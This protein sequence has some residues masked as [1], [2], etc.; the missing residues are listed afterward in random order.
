MGP[1]HNAAATA[2]PAP[3]P[4]LLF[5]CLLPLLSGGANPP[6]SD[7]P[8]SVGA[9][10]AMCDALCVAVARL[11]LEQPAEQQRPANMPRDR[12]AKAAAAAAAACAPATLAAVHALLESEATPPALLPP[13]LRLL[14][15][16]AA[17]APGALRALGGD[18]A[19]LLL[20]WALDAGVCAAGRALIPEALRALAPCWEAP[21]A[22]AAAAGVARSVLADLERLAPAAA[23]GTAAGPAGL[24]PPQFCGLAAC[25]VALARGFPR[26]RQS[27]GG[28]GADGG[29]D[30]A[31]G[32]DLGDVPGRLLWL[33]LAVQ[34]R[35]AAAAAEAVEASGGCGGAAAKEA[36]RELARLAL[37]AASVA[38]DGDEGW[39]GAA[40]GALQAALACLEA[41]A[42]MPRAAAAQ[43]L[44]A[45]ALLLC[46]SAESGREGA[47]ALRAALAAA[48]PRL[49]AATAPLRAS[50]HGDVAAA[51]A[52]L[53]LAALRQCGDT[54]AAALGAVALAALVE[55]V[56]ALSEREIGSS[57]GEGEALRLLAFDLA[58]LEAWA[59][60][61]GG[62]AMPLTQALAAARVAAA[63]L[64]RTALSPDGGGAAGEEAAAELSTLCVRL[65]AALPRGA[66]KA[67]APDAGAA[68][69]QAQL[70]EAAGEGLLLAVEAGARV[71]PADQELALRAA[72]EAA[73]RGAAAL[74]DEG[75][76]I[77]AADRA[78]SM[79]ARAADS[80]EAR[81][82][83]AAVAAAAAAAHSALL[84][85]GPPDGRGG[86]DAAARAL[87]VV[88]ALASD[89][90]GATAA[91]AQAALCDLAL[92]AYLL[93]AARSGRDS[94]G[95]SDGSVGSGCDPWAPSRRER[96]ALQRPVRAFRS[97]QLAALF[98]GLMRAP[99]GL[100]LLTR[101]AA[102]AAAAA[103]PGAGDADGG[104]LAGPA[105]LALARELPPL[106]PSAAGGEAPAATA[107]AKKQGRRQQQEQQPQ[108]PQQPPPQQQQ[109]QSQQPP[110][111]EPIDPSQL[112]AASEAAWFL[113][114]EAARHCAAARMRTH[115]GGPTESFAGLERLLQGALARL[116][117]AAAA[118]AAAAAGAAA[119]AGKPKDEAASAAA[120]AAA[121]AELALLRQRHGAA[122]LLEFAF[123]LEAGVLA[124]AEGCAGRAAP[125]QAALAFFAANKRVRCRTR[126]SH[127]HAWQQPSCTTLAPCWLAAPIDTFL[128]HL[129]IQNTH[130]HTQP[131]VC[132]EWFARQRGTLARLAAA[133]GLPH[134][135]LHH[136]GARLLDVK[137]QLGSLAAADS[138]FKRRLQQ[139]KRNEEEQGAAGAVVA[140]EPASPAPA[141]HGGRSGGRGRGGRGGRGKGRGREPAAPG[142][143]KPAAAPAL[144][145]EEHAA[146]RDAALR[147]LAPTAAEALAACAAALVALRDADGVRGLRDWAADAFAPLWKLEAQRFEFLSGGGGGS[148]ISS[149]SAE[150]GASSPAGGGG[151]SAAGAAF[152]LSWLDG[153]E[154]AAAGRP[155]DAARLLARFLSRLPQGG[156]SGGESGAGGDGIGGPALGAAVQGLLAEQLG[157]AYAALADWRAL[158]ALQA[159]VR[160]EAG[161]LRAAA[162]AAASA[163]AAAAEEAQQSG[164]GGG[165]GG[166]DAAGAAAAAAAAQAR[167]MAARAAAA[168]A[169]AQGADTALL[170]CWAFAGADAEALR[171]ATPSSTSGLIAVCLAT[172]DAKAVGGAVARQLPAAA[173]ALADD[174]RRRAALLGEWAGAAAFLGA[175]AAAPNLQHLAALRLL[176][177]LMATAPAAKTGAA[178]ASPLAAAAGAIDQ[179]LAVGD[180]QGSGGGGGGGW[181]A[182]LSDDGSVA[183][184]RL[185]LS[186][187]QLSP[188]L[189]LLE[190]GRK[191]PAAAGGEECA[192]L[193]GVVQRRAA[194]AAWEAG[195]AASL[196]R[197]IA[198]AAADADAG[199]SGGEAGGQQRQ[200]L[201]IVGSR[202]LLDCVPRADAE[203][204]QAAMA[205]A[206]KEHTSAL[207]RLAGGAAPE[208]SDAVAAMSLFTILQ[209]RRQQQLGAEEA[210]W[211]GLYAS[212]A[213]RL[214]LSMPS[215]D[216]IASAG[217]LL[218]AAACC[219]VAVAAAPARPGAWRAL[220]DFAY[221]LA[222][223]QLEQQQ[224]GDDQEQ[225]DAPA[226]APVTLPPD[227]AAAY[228][229]AADAYS[230]HLATAAASRRLSAAEDGLPAL[231]RLLRLVLRRAAPLE[232]PL[233]AA[234]LRTPAAAWQALA[235]QLLSALGHAD[236]AARRLAALLLRGVAAAAP[237]AV[238]Y[239]SIA[240]L[241][242]A[243][244]RGSGG[245]AA[246]A[247]APSAP[248]PAASPE[249]ESVLRVLRR[250]D[251][252]LVADAAAL[253]DG[254]EALTV[255]P[256]E[257][258]AALLAELE[259]GVARK[260]LALRADAARIEAS[261]RVPRARRAELLAARYS[262]LVA[263]A[264]AAL[265]RQLAASTAGAPASR[266]DAEFRAT[267]LPA[268]ARAI[269]AFRS[270]ARVAAALTAEPGDGSSAGAGPGAAAE[271]PAVAWAPLKALQQALAAR[272][273]R[274]GA[275]DLPA[276]APA[277]AALRAGAIPM[278]AD[279]LTRGALPPL[280]L[281]DAAGGDDAASASSGALPPPPPLV[282]EY[283][284]ITAI[285]P[286]ALV[287]PTKTRPKRLRLLASDGAAHAFLLKG[288]D[289]LRVDE[290]LMQFVRAA[291]AAARD[292]AAL[293][294]AG[295]AGG[296]GGCGGAA[297]P[298]IELRQYS[299]TPL[300]PRAGLVQWVRGTASVFALFR[301][302]QAAAAARLEAV[303]AARRAA[304]AAAAAAPAAATS[305]AAAAGGGRGGR[306][307][308]GKRKAKMQA[309]AAVGKD[310]AQSEAPPQPPLQLPL[311]VAAARPADAYYA[312]L[313]PALRAAGA[314]PDAPREAWPRAALRATFASLARDAPRRLLAD[315][316][317]AGAGSAPAWWAR[318]RRY[319][320]SAAA[321]AIVGWLLGVG[322][323]HPDNILLDR[324]T[325]EVV[326]VD[327]SVCLDKG[328][329][330]RV[331]EVVPFRLTPALQAALGP[332]GKEGAFRA[333]CERA[334]RS[335]RASRAPLA[336]LLALLLEDPGVDW[337]AEREAQAARRAADAA[338]ALEL[339]ASRMDEVRRPLLAALRGALPLAGDALAA[340]CAYGAAHAFMRGA[341]ERAA[342]ARAE[343]A[344]A[345]DSAARA[346]ADEAAAR[347]AAAAAA[348]E[349]AAAGAEV[350]RLGELAGGA[351]ADASS[352][353][354]R[355]LRTLAGLKDVPLPPELTAPSEA[356]RSDAA[357]LLLPLVAPGAAADAALGG[358]DGAAGRAL[359]PAVFTQCAAADA[360]GAA[361]LTAR[362]AALTNA[363][364]ALLQYSLV[365]RGVLPGESVGPVSWG[366]GGAGPLL[367]VLLCLNTL[368]FM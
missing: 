223:R 230:R 324:A 224:G 190:A 165:G 30:E 88:V 108:Q 18:L 45:V 56:Q 117:A 134:H 55:E 93:A 42:A 287:L 179:L 345:T 259:G 170:R 28:A 19:D 32:G 341:E 363:L 38:D 103:A 213:A 278:P 26:A 110:C 106:P 229:L 339:L 205:T 7:R 299:V 258:W 189:R 367:I 228:A 64:R 210:D 137:A 102:V 8:A 337:A 97:A 364:T 78:L 208:P 358:P 285:A 251:A 27:G 144:S 357:P 334:L 89:G 328:A 173:A 115:L 314:P 233:R 206:I 105:L 354:E 242:A 211:R 158:G 319:C 276:A 164:G 303:E 31:A 2:V 149:G 52:E 87:G 43:M 21:A 83:A 279:D 60:G 195:D 269:E 295:A 368:S 235:P 96:A 245:Q 330:L 200:W 72:A 133:A 294:C 260:A 101:P 67:R 129:H 292:A 304:E 92:P 168:A 353:C 283:P 123:A 9:R 234:L 82:R 36:S 187:P 22:R 77:A 40:C 296:S 321:G 177:A 252:R 16:L 349:S 218:P 246:A 172:V 194:L 34:R 157:A 65:L 293:A 146:R 175:E 185:E 109:L 79:A 90:D 336:A 145:P 6:G 84:G 176:P 174:C 249:L 148:S 225:Q 238:L 256:P 308:G 322:D 332:T 257:R 366:K 359:P 54:T 11:P 17:K 169:A 12:A 215:V 272:Y 49:A 147:R 76:R 222:R 141:A 247:D 119:T 356:W 178:A 311:M 25:L 310:K 4:T 140:A 313:L 343:R 305:T 153:L 355:H 86:G 262:T 217:G 309:A 166:R 191:L 121:A 199:D 216:V 94:G 241:R 33:L 127:T 214:E 219:M 116:Q 323:R 254:L 163:A 365:L 350:R 3:R 342:A 231:L 346:R 263:P 280:P 198:A 284:T 347:A 253:V 340:L 273:L 47:A 98:D 227:A 239:P 80:P 1:P 167:S 220:G 124:A 250:R 275:L 75:T 44:E 159:E 23:G 197:L 196:E 261:G 160:A 71:A 182:L 122:H 301:A 298:A 270:P 244:A 361:L 201:R 91:A 291:N 24:P 5:D 183:R 171:L 344:A 100:A 14:L 136:A 288:A 202:L 236:P 143:A 315:E 282:P 243:E 48:W 73:A 232:A 131:Q 161:E 154:A 265:E 268:A 111:P 125:A 41:A 307:S 29:T 226:A 58:V 74:A 318:R 62:T 85:A 351:L 306:G 240:E 221:A 204:H 95:G 271:A 264:V 248:A 297:A 120:A 46:T 63:L 193:F 317:W 266:D 50:P 118:A 162:A 316:L 325:G 281:E 51:A 68:Q 112:T 37:L 184:G 155:G 138:D 128:H 53:H 203:R 156:G 69:A 126:G 150:A 132:D 302:W 333:A 39:S 289:D 312:R 70:L 10:A 326:H 290:R 327:L 338:A 352:W 277:L 151:D 360:R 331:P 286:R 130:D 192:R 99:P 188:L 114:Q 335:L 13:L 209:R 20:G 139:Q 15:R 348:A 207:S 59:R 61:N 255:T 212:A 237:C 274:R 180:V 267:F 320:V 329:L 142:D 66:L 81:V 113:C 152:V 181:A 362:D 135:A 35:A 186:L 57:G 300:G 107:Q 104:R